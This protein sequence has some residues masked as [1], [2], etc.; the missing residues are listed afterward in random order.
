[1]VYFNSTARL[2]A[3]L[4]QVPMGTAVTN[5]TVSFGAM[6]LFPPGID[7]SSDGPFF[8]LYTA[9]SANPCTQ[10]FQSGAPND[11]KS[12]IVFFPGIAGLSQ[13][14]ALFCGLRPHPLFRCHT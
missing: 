13:N 7:G 5:R 9:D 11:K 2:A 8:N 6:P 3:D 12:G 14:G 4:N 10:G 1:M